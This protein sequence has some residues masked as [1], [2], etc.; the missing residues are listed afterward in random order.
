MLHPDSYGRYVDLGLHYLPVSTGYAM[1]EV[2]PIMT[3]L[4]GRARRHRPGSPPCP[5]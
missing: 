3:N 5:A 4:S 2:L 1:R